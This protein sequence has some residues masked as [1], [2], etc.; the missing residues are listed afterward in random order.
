MLA[1]SRFLYF[2]VVVMVRIKVPT[3]ERRDLYVHKSRIICRAN[4]EIIARILVLKK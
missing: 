2:M 4:E 1:S 3:N